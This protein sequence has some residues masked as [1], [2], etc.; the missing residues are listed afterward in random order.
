MPSVATFEHSRRLTG[1][2]LHFDAVGA[3]LETVG[4]VPDEARLHAW[5]ILIERMREQLAWPAG[6]VLWRLHATGAS[7]ALVAPVDQLFTATEVNEWAWLATGAAGRGESFHA[8]G[9]AAA[10]DEGSA[11]HTLHALAAGERIAKLSALLQAAEAHQLTPLLDEDELSIGMGS[12]SQRWPL[13]SLPVPQAIAWHELYDIPV[14]LVTGS[15][16]KTTTVRL[17]AAIARTHGWHTAYSCT[18]G[19][20]LGDKNFEAGDYSGPAGARAVL[21]QREVEVAILETARG[22]ILRRG[23]AVPRAQVAIVTNIS[24]DHFGEYGIHDLDALAEVKLVVAHTLGASGLLV[25]NAD[26]AV[27]VRH[28]EKRCD[29]IAWFALDDAHPLLCAQREH[30]GTTCGVRDGHLRLCL[31]GSDYDLGKIADMPLTFAGSAIY[32]IAN[33]SAAVLAATELGVSTNIIAA[34]LGCFGATHSDNPGRLQ[35]WQLGTLQV[36]L[37]YAHNVEGLRGLLSVATRQRGAGR[38]VLVLGQAGNREDREIRELAEVVA[39]FRPE[40]VVLKDID[41]MLRGRAV[42]EVA[43]ILRQE[44]VHCGLHDDTIVECLEEF[45]AARS[46]LAS[47]RAGDVVVLPIHSNSARNSVVGWLDRLQASGWRSGMSVPMA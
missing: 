35:H 28:A 17:L 44:L 45:E 8:P 38:L 4:E 20:F 10:W 16:G 39:S 26:D 22:G 3:V 11:L 13:T 21:R 6:A 18:D 5:K 29:R 41:G 43:K 25:L 42:G 7:L 9:H 47:A 12:G 36:F 30:G 23:I 24:V 1:F 32:N 19:L 34:V 15:N 33:I 27:L 37:D 31:H 46:A 2:N 14:A 40:R